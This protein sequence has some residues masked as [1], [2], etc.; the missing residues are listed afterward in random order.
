MRPSKDIVYCKH[1]GEA[2]ATNFSGYASLCEDCCTKYGNGMTTKVI[3]TRGYEIP[4][5]SF[6]GDCENLDAKNGYC[7]AFVEEL[8]ETEDGDNL[9]KCDACKIGCRY[10]DYDLTGRAYE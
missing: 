10:G 3:I 9:N 1:C 8:Y 5:G 6:C 2:E 4:N 7:N